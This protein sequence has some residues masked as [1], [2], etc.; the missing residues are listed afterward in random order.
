M[1]NGYQRLAVSIHAALFA[2]V[3]A[4]AS[5]AQ[6]AR[7]PSVA[8]APS[9]LLAIDQNRAQIV[10]R[11]VDDF[12]GNIA[13]IQKSAPE[14]GLTT[15]S[16]RAQLQGLRA[17][18]LLAASLSNNLSGVLEVIKRAATVTSL[19]QQKTLG[20]ATTDL[21]YV[22]LSPCRLFDTRGFA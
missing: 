6:S 3:L 2:M 4:N 15:E 18:Q 19:D 11:L 1:K 21:V 20:D 13:E 17:D 8:A 10:T 22:P 9:S 12:S 5:Q 14:F 7:L 16:L